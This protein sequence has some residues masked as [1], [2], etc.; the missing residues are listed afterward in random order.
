[1]RCLRWSYRYVARIDNGQ[2]ML[3]PEGALQYW[4]TG[5][6]LAGPDV[7]SEN[8][9]RIPG[10]RV[11]WTKR[12]LVREHSRPPRSEVLPSPKISMQTRRGNCEGIVIDEII[13]GR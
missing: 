1:M 9:W 3:K 4:N 8:Q 11:I 2:T 7:W 13:V 6:P 10:L 5:V 12:R